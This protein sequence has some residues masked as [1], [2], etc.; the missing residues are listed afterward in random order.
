MLFCSILVD[1]W[2]SDILSLLLIKQEDWV[3][4]RVFCKSRGVTSRP[5]LETNCEDSSYSALP[6][7]MDTYIT[8]DQA[9]PRL[10]G[11][12]QVPCFSNFPL[13]LSS[14]CPNAT[15]PTIPLV[16]KSLTTKI[17]AHMGGLPADMGSCD[18]K[19]IRAVL[20]HLTKLEDNPKTEVH[21]NLAQGSL[22]TYL[23]ENGLSNIWNTL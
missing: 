10:E 15:V 8:F 12:K 5:I 16:E 6:P 19:D 20:N 14:H 13:D 3:L 23:T 1:W 21:P 7:L 2:L 17:S 4:C 18:K 22:E 11:H 9:P